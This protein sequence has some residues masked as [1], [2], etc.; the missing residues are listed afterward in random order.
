MKRMSSKPDP[1][2]LGHLGHLHHLHR[3]V[4]EGN[5]PKKVHSTIG[6]FSDI[7]LTFVVLSAF[8]YL[9]IALQCES[10][11]FRKFVIATGFHV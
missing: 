5:R 3:R 11:V 8:I 4:A 10:F 1:E 2:D 7:H 9:I 6:G